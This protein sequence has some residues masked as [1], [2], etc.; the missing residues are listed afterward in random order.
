MGIDE[1]G[2]LA[3]VLKLTEEVTA[4]KEG[5][6]LPYQGLWWKEIQ[7]LSQL[8]STCCLLTLRLTVTQEVV[9]VVQRWHRMQERSNHTTSNVENE[10]KRLL[11]KL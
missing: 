3:L 11:G 8:D 9:R 5:V 2:R 1:L 10:S 7:R 4:D 6:G